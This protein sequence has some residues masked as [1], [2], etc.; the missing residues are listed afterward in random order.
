[1]V[2]I[3]SNDDGRKQENNDG[4][5]TAYLTWFHCADILGGK[6]TCTDPFFG[7]NFASF[8]RDGY[9]D[10]EGGDGGVRTRGKYMCLNPFLTSPKS[11]GSYAA[12]ILFKLL[13]STASMLFGL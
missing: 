2:A 9:W 6:T 10:W 13:N 5:R 1:M 8:G 7:K 11:A 12:K 4:K 3:K